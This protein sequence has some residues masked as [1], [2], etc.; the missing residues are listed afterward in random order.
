MIINNEDK[1]K[2]KELLNLYYWVI[3]DERFL[4]VLD[5]YSNCEG[6]GVE[7]IWCCFANEYEEWE[8]DYFGESGVAYYFD[9]PA[10]EKDFTIILNNEEFYKYLFETCE[11]YIKKHEEE[12]VVIYEYLDKIKMNLS[13]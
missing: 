13:L 10:V 7:N 11:E 12:K 6:F 3:G 4:S 9:Y 2:I 8:E 1:S 5:K